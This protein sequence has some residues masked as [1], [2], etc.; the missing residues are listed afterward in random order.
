MKWL[1]LYF[2]YTF[3]IARNVNANLPLVRRPQDIFNVR[4]EVRPWENT[5]FGIGVLQV[6]SRTTSTP[7][8]AR[9]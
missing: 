7:S 9:S 1:D 6:S 2:D 5:L 3:T 4:A 8:P